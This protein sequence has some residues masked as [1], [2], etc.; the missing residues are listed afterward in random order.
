MKADAVETLASLDDAVEESER[1][2]TETHDPLRLAVDALLFRSAAKR[3]RSATN[4]ALPQNR[5]HRVVALVT[6]GK[7]DEVVGEI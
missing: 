4:G 5:Q 7:M 3:R 2:F 1:S 6:L